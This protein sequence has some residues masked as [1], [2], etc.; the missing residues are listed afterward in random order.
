MRT[1]GI[2]LF[3]WMPFV[4]SSRGRLFTGERAGDLCDRLGESGEDRE[5]ADNNGAEKGSSNAVK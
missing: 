5:V 4:L 2:T 1:G 3:C